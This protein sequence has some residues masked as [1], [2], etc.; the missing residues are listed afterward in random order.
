MRKYLY[1]TLLLISAIMITVSCKKEEPSEEI[2][3]DDVALNFAPEKKSLQVDLPLDENS[4]YWAHLFPDR[5]TP[6]SSMKGFRAGNRCMW[7]WTGTRPAKCV[8]HI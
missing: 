2:M 1:P 3:L 7:P 8:L 5:R 6:G 4:N